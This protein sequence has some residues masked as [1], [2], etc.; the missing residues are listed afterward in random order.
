MA[1]LPLSL[2]AKFYQPRPRQKNYLTPA[3]SGGC[4]DG[5]RLSAQTAQQG[6]ARPANLATELRTQ[7]RK[8]PVGN[9]PIYERATPAQ[10]AFVQIHDSSTLLTPST[11][12]RRIFLFQLS[13][14]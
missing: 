6:G 4:L 2:H 10:L 14:L 8:G 12:P 13:N 5:Q 11:D 3:D 9:S 1:H 7:S